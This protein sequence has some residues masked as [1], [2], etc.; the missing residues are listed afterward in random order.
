MFCR[1]QGVFNVYLPPM[2]FGTVPLMGALL[3]LLLPETRG[4]QLPVTIEDGE[5]FGLKVT[6]VLLMQL[7]YFY[8]NCY[9]MR[10]LHII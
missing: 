7:C 6:Y 3:C 8:N 1:L 4:A 9:N 2:I 5:R 10:Y